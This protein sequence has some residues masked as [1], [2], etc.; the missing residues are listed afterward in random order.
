MCLGVFCF[1]GMGGPGLV[2]GLG[3]F[4]SYTGSVALLRSRDGCNIA[5][6][7]FWTHHSTQVP[8]F[9]ATSAMASCSIHATIWA[10]SVVPVVLTGFLANYTVLERLSIR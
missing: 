7:T 5:G 8:V 10:S 3:Q 1:V 2:W 6:W 9:K 4:L